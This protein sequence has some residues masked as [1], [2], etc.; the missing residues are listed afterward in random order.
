MAV[1]LSDAQRALFDAK[2]FAS[3]A[4]LNK[5]GSPQVTPVWVGYDG[6]HVIFNTEIKRLKTKNMR[7]DARVSVSVQNLENPYVYIEVRG[8]VVEITEE[9]GDAGIDA[10]AK[11]YLG[12]DKYPGNQPGDVRVNVK[13]EIERVSGQGI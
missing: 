11:K 6:Q 1:K 12:M 13:V 8:K 9:D 3:V 2:N 7:R 10:M 5:D 4:T